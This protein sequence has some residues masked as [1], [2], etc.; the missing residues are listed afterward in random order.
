MLFCLSS[1]SFPEKRGA[2]KSLEPV[3]IDDLSITSS[4]IPK[5]AT[6]FCVTYYDGGY[7]LLSTV[8]GD[9]YLLV[10]DDEVI[11]PGFPEDVT[12]INGCP[13]HIYMAA[14][15]IMSFFVTMQKIDAI[16]FSS[17]E[18]DGWHIEEARNAMENGQITYA[19]KYSAPDYEMLIDRGC[20]LTIESTMI[21]HTPEVAEKLR[22]S[23]I[24]VMTDYS[25]YE[26]DPLGRSEWIVFYGALLG[27]E[28]TASSFFDSQVELIKGI[29][30]VEPSGK[31][32]A[33]FFVNAAGGIVTRRSDDYIPRMIEMGGGSYI[34]D[35]L[36]S[37]N[38]ESHSGSV[39][40]TAEQFYADAYDAD[41]LIYN[42]T[43]DAPLTSVDE[44]LDK[45]PMF[46][47]FD[48]VKNDSV[49]TVSRDLYQS[50]DQMAAMIMDIHLLVSSEDPK[51]Q[52]Y[53]FL[54]HVE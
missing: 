50:T 43:I 23:G 15:A 45:D 51:D 14:S 16:S 32:I 31:T 20:D 27:C 5:Y 28:D 1:C 46:A 37:T 13:S 10:P 12:V 35:D 29:G 39:T 26:D 30:D 19:G 8:D 9:D 25:S 36:K 38:S 2:D 18:A 40:M 49:Y 33:F 22:A 11:P 17:L 34:F 41:I 3:E 48:A 6:G 7:K 52:E 54:E 44:L 47:K 53:T 42:G 21:L 24:P 4:Y